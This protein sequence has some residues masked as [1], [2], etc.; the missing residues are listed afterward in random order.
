M[1]GSLAIRL[2]VRFRLVGFLTLNVLHGVGV[3]DFGCRPIVTYRRAQRAGV[4]K[5][6]RKEPAGRRVDG[7]RL[8]GFDGAAAW[9]GDAFAGVVGG[10]DDRGSEFAAAAA[11]G[12][13]I[14]A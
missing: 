14:L 2:N 8:W 5:P 3:K 10:S 13:A 11:V 7:C 6:P 12:W 4:R 9:D 1:P